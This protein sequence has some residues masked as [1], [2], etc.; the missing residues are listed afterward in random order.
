M[1]EISGQAGKALDATKRDADT[2]ASDVSLSFESLQADRLTWS[3]VGRLSTLADL[4]IPELGQTVEAW[5]DGTR[6]FS[7]IVT[8]APVEI[9]GDS[10]SV[11]VT[12][13]GPHWWLDK[14]S[15]TEDIEGADEVTQERAVYVFAAGDLGASFTALFARA[16]AEGLPVAKGTIAALYDAP[17]MTVADGSF[18]D[19]LASLVRM[20]PDAMTWWDYSVA[21]TPEFN[22]SRRGTATVLGLTYGTAPLQSAR[23]EPRLGLEASEVVLQYAERGDDGL[24]NYKA[25]SSGVAAAGKRQ[26]VVTSGR[27]LGDFIEVEPTEKVTLTTEEM[28]GFG[29]GYV[30]NT[31]KE[32]W[33]FWK[34]W[35]EIHESTIA[36]SLPLFRW[37]S[38]GDDPTRYP[39]GVISYYMDED[40]DEFTG[41]SGTDL[42]HVVIVPEKPD[43]PPWLKETLGYEDIT[44][45]GTVW[46][47]FTVTAATTYDDWINYALNAADHVHQVLSGGDVT[48]WLFYNVDIP[49]AA[50]E[51]PLGPYDEDDFFQPL[52]WQFAAPPA[53]FAASL[54]AAQAFLPY[55]GQVVLVEQDAGG[56]EPMGKVLNV[57]GALTEWGTMK[58]MVQ[59]VDLT[60]SNGTQV[61]R[62]GAPQ[63]LSYQ[64]ITSRIRIDPRDNIIE[65]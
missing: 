19:A 64:D 46:T 44:F 2:V 52:G 18:A 33:P 45:T 27:E 14:T 63:S 56:V 50:V 5:R 9:S 13:E 36:P 25:Q 42:E 40:R 35:H 31:I 4:T 11:Q 34:D 51:D 6:R 57:S 12:V 24:V 65:L 53:G 39:E 48:F 17:Q 62:L 61:I 37:G 41:A 30:V 54:Q 26:V 16:V 59:G 22:L 49:L 10:V 58:A 20:I 3:V 23:L 21:G 38:G 60:L 47:T 8:S 7:G 28:W 32:F 55:S 1:W 29:G 43:L 15:I